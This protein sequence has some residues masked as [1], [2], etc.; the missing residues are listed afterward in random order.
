MNKNN[1]NKE[2]MEQQ[3]LIKI[4]KE[5]LEDCKKLWKKYYD[6]S[7]VNLIFYYWELGKRINQEYGKPKVESQDTTRKTGYKLNDSITSIAENLREMGIT[8]T[9]CYGSQSIKKIKQ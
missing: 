6:K 9:S 5:L 8:I 4:D 2:K 7:R 3:K 1:K